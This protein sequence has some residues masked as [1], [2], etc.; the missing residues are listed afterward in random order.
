MTEPKSAHISSGETV[1]F[2]LLEF[3]LEDQRDENLAWLRAFRSEV[4]EF[5]DEHCFKVGALHIL[6]KPYF[7]IVESFLRKAK[8]EYKKRGY[9]PI[10]KFLKANIR[11]KDYLDLQTL[12]LDRIRSRLEICLSRLES[13]EL[14][15]DLFSD[16]LREVTKA[17]ELM[18]IFQLSKHFPREATRVY[19]LISILNE[20]TS[21][22]KLHKSKEV[23]VTEL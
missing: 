9:N 11:G 3:P 10:F 20:K 8:I 21:E 22:F 4:E 5:C 15:D 2:V 18:L 1:Y 13:E 12:I 17:N 16:A 23:V 6:P 7:P 14:K 19:D